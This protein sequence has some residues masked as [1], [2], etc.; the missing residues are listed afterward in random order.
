[1]TVIVTGLFDRYSDAKQA[2]HALEQ[3]GVDASDISLIANN[4]ENDP[5]VNGTDDAIQGAGTGA[6]VGAAV[7]GIGALLAGL[8]VIAI[9]G[10][11]PVVAAGWLTSTLTGALAGGAVGAAV[12]SIVGALTAEGVKPED[13]EIYAEHIRRGGALLCVRA[14]EEDAPAINAV[15]ASYQTTTLDARREAYS[16]EGWEGFD[17][18][19]QPLSRDRISA[20]RNRH[21]PM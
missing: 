8:G 18:H 6:G 16:D 21:T 15:I 3:R 13:A 14:E 10:I 4:V 17:P 7:G 20:E 12:G 1:M 11:G 19:A 2:L 5:E 9:P